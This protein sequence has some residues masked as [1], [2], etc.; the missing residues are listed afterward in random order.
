MASPFSAWRSGSLD[1]VMNFARNVLMFFFPVGQLMTLPRFQTLV[2][3]PAAASSFAE[4][5]P[6]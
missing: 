2:Y 6:A 4:P 5:L 3:T 1:V